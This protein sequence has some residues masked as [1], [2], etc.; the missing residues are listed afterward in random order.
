MYISLQHLL[1]RRSRKGMS[2]VGVYLGFHLQQTPYHT[3]T[4]TECV[5]VTGGFDF[6][7]KSLI[8]LFRTPPSFLLL[9]SLFFQ[10]TLPPPPPPLP[11][12]P[13]PPPL[14]LSPSP[15]S[16]IRTTLL[17]WEGGR[18]GTTPPGPPLLADDDVGGGWN[19]ENVMFL[20]GVRTAEEETRLCSKTSGSRHENFT[21][22]T[23]NKIKM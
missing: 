10:A 4:L 22:F 3:I 12:P 9:G 5:H 19:G 14:L 13:T 15:P 11:S 16:P 8:K 17:N 1:Q 23:N 20:G 2:S 21:R 18:W 6:G 7:A